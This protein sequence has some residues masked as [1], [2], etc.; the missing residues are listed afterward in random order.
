MS[1]SAKK[2]KQW[3]KWAVAVHEFD[4]QLYL[5]TGVGVACPP[6]LIQTV[7][8]KG[9][10]CCCSR[11]HTR[12]FKK[13]QKGS[14][15]PFQIGFRWLKDNKSFSLSFAVCLS[16]CVVA[17]QLNA[18]AHR[19]YYCRL[20]RKNGRERERLVCVTL[21]YSNWSEEDERRRQL[22]PYSCR[23]NQNPRLL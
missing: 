14:K 17:G 21:E 9:L 2:W 11:L 10:R 13:L 12:N 19:Q 5:L 4:E 23:Q 8:Q 6:L 16:V 20:F 7:H 3:R 18:T 22:S 1:A 15:T